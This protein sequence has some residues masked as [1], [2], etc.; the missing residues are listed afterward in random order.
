MKK[1]K[2]TKRET[3]IYQPEECLDCRFIKGLDCKPH[4]VVSVFESDHEFSC[5]SKIS[6]K[7]KV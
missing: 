2:L 5:I 6:N 3:V 4:K 7:E 1:H